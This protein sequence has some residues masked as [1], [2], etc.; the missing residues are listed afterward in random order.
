MWDS[1]RFSHPWL[2]WCA[3]HGRTGRAHD[4]ESRRWVGEG[5]GTPRT[6]SL[7]LEASQAAHCQHSPKQISDCLQEENKTRLR[8][9][10]FDDSQITNHFPNLSSLQR[11][12]KSQVL[13]LPSVA[14]TVNPSPQETL[15]MPFPPKGPTSSWTPWCFL[16]SFT[17]SCPYLLLPKVIRRPLSIEQHTGC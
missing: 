13:C 7:G 2:E 8:D 9:T 1:E 4:G 11:K 15:V 14:A 16:K 12:S 10:R 3:T 6:Q 5:Q 17:P